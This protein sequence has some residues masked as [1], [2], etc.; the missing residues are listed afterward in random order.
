MARLK[1]MARK[2]TGH[3]YSYMNHFRNMCIGR[4]S[5]I[6][7]ITLTLESDSKAIEYNTNDESWSNDEIYPK[8]DSKYEDSQNKC[9]YD[10]PTED[11]EETEDGS[12]DN[13]SPFEMGNSDQNDGNSMLKDPMPVDLTFEEEGYHRREQGKGTHV[14]TTT[15]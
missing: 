10:Y 11:D 4:G 8:D 3:R 7:L 14:P 12:D 2:N 5:K 6:D 13:E 1:H 15:S 9:F